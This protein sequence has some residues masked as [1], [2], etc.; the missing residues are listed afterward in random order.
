MLPFM[1]R[2][3]SQSIAPDIGM[4]K[5]GIEE[6]MVRYVLK[7]SPSQRSKETTEPSLIMSELTLIFLHVK[8]QKNKSTTLRSSIHLRVCPIGGCSW[9]GSIRHWYQAH[10]QEEM[11]RYYSLTWT[12]SRSSTTPSVMNSA[13]CCYNR[14]L[15]AY[16]H[17]YAMATP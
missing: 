2:C 16:S 1:L 5:S 11:V 3:G 8:C 14:L 17:V 9:I 6:K 10:V 12:I 4:E 15:S 7:F 13:I